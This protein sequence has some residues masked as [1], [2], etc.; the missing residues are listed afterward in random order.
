MFYKG[1]RR[2]L[3]TPVS[4]QWPC[5]VHCGGVSVFHFGVH[6]PQLVCKKKWHH[7]AQGI[8]VG[9]KFQVFICMF[10]NLPR[11]C[12]NTLGGSRLVHE[13]CLPIK[14]S[15]IG[16]QVSIKGWILWPLLRGHFFR[17]L[18]GGWHPT[19][20]ERWNLPESRCV[21]NYWPKWQWFASARYSPCGHR[22]SHKDRT[23]SKLGIRIN[24]A[25]LSCTGLCCIFAG[26]EP[27][28]EISKFPFVATSLRPQ[29]QPKLKQREAFPYL[30]FSFAPWLHGESLPLVEHTLPPTFSE[31]FQ[32]TVK[33]TVKVHIF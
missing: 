17:W 21:A 4:P 10:Q 31:R 32:T 15:V 7:N 27:T 5:I 11:K 23:S 29:F 9:R 1:A 8:P 18:D 3:R 26:P 12:W 30:R 25:A 16:F 33:T 20:S 22:I 19:C 14:M 6:G 28:T 2:L 24:P 13:F